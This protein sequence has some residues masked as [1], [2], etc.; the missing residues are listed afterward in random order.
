MILNALRKILIGMALFLVVGT[1]MVAAQS[2]QGASGQVAYRLTVGDHLR[3]TVYGHE[4][5]SGEFDID[6]TG[7]LS[8]PLIGD[9]RAAGLTANELEAAI[10]DQLRPD[11]LKNPRVS[12]E[13]TDY[14]PFYI[15]GEVKSPGSYPYTSGMTVISS[16]AVAG[17][18]TYRARKN[19]IRIVRGAGDAQVKLEANDDTP[20]LPGD[21]IEIPE[22]FF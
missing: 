3:V 19:R 17:G 12:A 4:D 15:F 7:N 20:I 11:Y 22:R 6:G 8:L 10:T 13:L 9:V 14:R 21:V 16:I 1:T 18:F 2:P 5:L